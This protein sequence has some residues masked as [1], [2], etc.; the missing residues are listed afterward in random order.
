MPVISGEKRENVDNLKKQSPEVKPGLHFMGFLVPG[1]V[2]SRHR[3]DDTEIPTKGNKK[4]SSRFAGLVFLVSPLM[5]AS[6]ERF[7]NK[8]T[9]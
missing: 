6:F 8:K 5:K 4:T 9:T 7:L 1:T 2:L 3:R